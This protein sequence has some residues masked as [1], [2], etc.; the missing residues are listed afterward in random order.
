[1]RNNARPEGEEEYA[2]QRGQQGPRPGEQ[3]AS[4]PVHRTMPNLL[5]GIGNTTKRLWEKTRL[6]LKKTCRLR[7][8]VKY[9]VQAGHIGDWWWYLMDEEKGWEADWRAALTHL[10]PEEC[11]AVAAVF[12]HMWDAH[13]RLCREVMAD[14]ELPVTARARVEKA[15]AEAHNALRELSTMGHMEASPWQHIMYCHVWQ[16]VR[17][18]QGV[19]FG[20]TWGLEGRH[21]QVK[22][23]LQCVYR[24]PLR[25][26]SEQSGPANDLLQRATIRM[27]LDMLTEREG[28]LLRTRL[29]RRS[30]TVWAAVLQRVMTL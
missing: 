7:R 22:R 15:S 21:V 13:A 12:L 17:V 30:P 10:V 23:D 9:P 1:M 18:H 14:G 11:K 3:F 29:P 2:W 20:S 4:I 24:G 19:K 8:A 5:H 28:L 16:F 27:L 26:G 6:F 25:Q